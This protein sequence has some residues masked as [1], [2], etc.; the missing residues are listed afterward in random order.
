MAKNNVLIIDD[1]PD[2]IELLAITLERMGLNTFS[3]GTIAQAKNL[4]NKH[5]FN[6]VL[7][8]LRLPD[9]SGLDLISEI[10]HSYPNTPVAMVTA[11]GTIEIAIEA[12]KKGAFDFIVKPIDLLSLRNMVKAALE[13]SAHNTEA[14]DTNKLLGNSVSIQEL[15]KKITKLSRTQ[16][17]IHITGPSGSGKELV[18]RLIHDLGPR[19]N[20]PFIAI[21]CGAV[22]PDLMESEFFGHKKGSFTGATV[23]KIGLFQAAEGGTLFLDEVNELPLHMQVKLLRAIQEKSIRVIG[24]TNEQAVDVRIL[25]ASNQDLHNLVNQGLFREDLYYRINVIELIVPELKEHTDDIPILTNFFITKLAEKN[26]QQAPKITPAAMDALNKYNFPGNVRELENILERAFA[27]CENNLIQ[28]DDLQLPAENINDAQKFHWGEDNIELYANNIEKNL[29]I[30]AL[31]DN[32]NDK[33]KAAEILGLSLRALR[34]KL[35][36]LD[37]E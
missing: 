16:A 13:V 10:Q 22:P 35:K 33:T 1:E 8:D 15:R 17:P 25:S 19:G 37:I 26:H 30:K 12:L 5:K 24:T 9:G 31:K 21:N 14:V 28:I 34:Y 6:L 7:L 36:K 27:M 20:K 3:A 18:A 32:N 11:Y 2:I 23:D 29:I 4:L